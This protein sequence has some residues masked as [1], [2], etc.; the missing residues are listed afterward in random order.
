[1]T[2][3][4]PAMVGKTLDGEPFALTDLAGKVVLI[5][6]WATWCGPCREELPELQRLHAA[7]NGRGLTVVGVSV[8]RRG[9]LRA[10]RAMADDFSLTYPIV[11]DPD[12]E[13][14]ADWAVR[15]YPTSFLVDREGMLRWRRDGIVRPDDAELGAAIE[16]ALAI[17]P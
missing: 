7:H 2:D 13:A 8:D 1:M 3:R 9:A 17:T 6:V 10:V 11:F 15:G 5:N 12:S 4:A 14:I 16:A